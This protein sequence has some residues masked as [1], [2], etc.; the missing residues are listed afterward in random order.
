M[1][2]VLDGS[3]NMRWVRA[4]ISITAVLGITIGFFFDKIAGETYI[5]LMAMAIAWWYKSRDDEK[6]Q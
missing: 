1:A 6:A 5:T 3:R 2:R 4:A